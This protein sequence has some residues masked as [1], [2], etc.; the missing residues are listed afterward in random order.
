MKHTQALFPKKPRGFTLVELMIVVAII[1][2]LAAIALPSYTSHVAKGNRAA[3]RAQLLQAAQYMQ[4]FYA[5]NDRYDTDRSGAKTAFETM[6]AALKQSPS[7][8]TALY[9]LTTGDLVVDASSFVIRMAPVA[10]TSME[11]DPCGKLTITQTGAKGRTGTGM[12]VADC[13]K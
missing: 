13:W 7:D 9:E 5:A 8:G 12:S 4:R 3:A 10:G 6:P 11:N 1:G 2:I